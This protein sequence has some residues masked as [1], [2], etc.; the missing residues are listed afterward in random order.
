MLVDARR[1]SGASTAPAARE[2]GAVV[3]DDLD[4]LAAD[5]GLEL[6]RGAA[7]DDLAVVDDGDLVGELVGLL[8]V[9]RRQQQ[10]A[11]SPHLARG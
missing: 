2:R 11:P 6:V 10:R 5:L 9:L 7:R 3:D 1:P 4:A 8:E